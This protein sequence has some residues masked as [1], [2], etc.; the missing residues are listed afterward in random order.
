MCALETLL[1]EVRTKYTDHIIKVN[2]SHTGYYVFDPYGSFLVEFSTKN[3]L[4]SE[5]APIRYI[6]TFKPYFFF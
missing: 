3:P 2:D 1:E 5:K 6:M 4:N